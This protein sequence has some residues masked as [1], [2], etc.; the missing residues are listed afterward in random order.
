M[1]T[2]P[3]FQGSFWTNKLVILCPVPSNT[4]QGYCITWGS[5]TCAVSLATIGQHFG[6][7]KIQCS[8][9]FNF[10]TCTRWFHDT[11]YIGLELRI[12]VHVRSWSCCTINVCKCQCLCPFHKACPS[13]AVVPE[14]VFRRIPNVFCLQ[15]QVKEKFFFFVLV[16]HDEMFCFHLS[17]RFW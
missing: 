6:H 5:K 9:M 8:V 14:Y 4:K 7:I 10:G 11:I 12:C 2:P 16:S 3:N 17:M 13:I 1:A 15:M